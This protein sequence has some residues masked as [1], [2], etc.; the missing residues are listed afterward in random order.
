[1]MRRIWIH[2]SQRDEKMEDFIR[3]KTTLKVELEEL[4]YLFGI[5]Q[6]DKKPN[7]IVVVFEKIITKIY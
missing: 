6:G 3:D 5:S 4:T 1:M 2:E 7:G